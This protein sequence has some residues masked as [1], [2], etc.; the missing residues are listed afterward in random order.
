MIAPGDKIAAE[1]TVECMEIIKYRGRD[2][3]AGRVSG[4]LMFC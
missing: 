3:F 2:F 1:S 4:I